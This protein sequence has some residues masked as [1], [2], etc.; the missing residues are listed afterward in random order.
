MS[1]QTNGQSR[2]SGRRALI[3]GAASGIGRATAQLFAREGAQ[4]VIADRDHDGLAQTLA[5]IGEGHRSIAFDAADTG[6]CADLVREASSGGLDILCNIA[7]LLDWGPSEEFGE[8]RFE[9]VLRINLF[10]PFAICRAALPH[11]LESK[12][13]IVNMASTA[14]LTGIP[15]S[16]AYAASKH[17]VI[18]LTKS[19]AAEFA[20]RGVRVNAVCPGH[21]DTPMGRM[22]PPPGEIDWAL[23]MRAAP[24]LADGICAPEDIA[25][26][27]AYLASED[28]RKIT[29][30]A[31]VIDGGHLA[32]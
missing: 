23:V 31:L 9:R 32:A 27:V 13:S 4:V 21:V 2:F 16:A 19:L 12:G 3:T 11:L 17:G 6:S 5:E 24:K 10:G 30:T 18:G 26:A 25:R 20:G 7:G 8:D 29:G 1:E 28:A 22:A 14:G 15:Y